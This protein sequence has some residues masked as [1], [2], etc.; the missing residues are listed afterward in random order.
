MRSRR[1]PTATGD[2]YEATGSTTGSIPKSKV[3]DHVMTIRTGTAQR[4]RVVF[5]SKNS[6]LTNPKTLEE[7]ERA[8]EN[9][10]AAVAV[11]VFGSEDHSPARV[12][13][14]KLARCRY[15]VVHPSD[16]SSDLSLRV[17]Y[18][19]ACAEAVDAIRDDASDDVDVELIAAKTAEAQELLNKAAQIKSGLTQAHGGLQ[20]A[21]AALEDMRQ[22]VA[23]VLKEIA[24][25][26]EGR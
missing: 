11:I 24:S 3:G 10:D 21:G 5:E 19:L 13:L 12:P 2:E 9:R 25:A 14:V 15:A 26:I 8:A 20:T 17:A 4:P 18:Q 6:R 1:S 16:G 23:A 7:L 22:R